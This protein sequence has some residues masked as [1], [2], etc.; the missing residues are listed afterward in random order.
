[1]ATIAQLSNQGWLSL[2]FQ[3][4]MDQHTI[5]EYFE[6]L[7]NLPNLSQLHVN[8]SGNLPPSQPAPS[9]PALRRLVTINTN[10]AAWVLA[11]R[12]PQFE[13]L[14]LHPDKHGGMLVGIPWKTLRGLTLIAQ[15]DEGQIA[16]LTADLEAHIAT[17]RTSLSDVTGV[18]DSL[19][20]D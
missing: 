12:Q 13:S 1:M 11:S 19:T 18:Q 6:D 16:A 8:I 20:G 3:G 5:L 14:D 17:V 4:E 7:A 9:L 15:L 2:R 10:L